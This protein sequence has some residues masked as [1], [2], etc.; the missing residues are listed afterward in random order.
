MRKRAAITGCSL[1]RSFNIPY[2]EGSDIMHSEIKKAF[3]ENTAEMRKI[4]SDYTQGKISYKE[5]CIRLKKNQEE[6]QHLLNICY[7]RY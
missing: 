6:L 7:G 5:H 1:F 2:N 3:D 4:Y